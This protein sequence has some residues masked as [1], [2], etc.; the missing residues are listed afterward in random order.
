LLG[1][2]RLCRFHPQRK[3]RPNRHGWHRKPTSALEHRLG[4]VEKRD[5]RLP[6]RSTPSEAAGR[7][8]HESATQGPCVGWRLS[9]PTETIVYQWLARGG[10]EAFRA[11]LPYFKGE[12]S[13]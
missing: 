7:N 10:T 4:S 1:G 13:K 6:S 5:I 3:P 11:M 2:G 8:H 12:V 9:G